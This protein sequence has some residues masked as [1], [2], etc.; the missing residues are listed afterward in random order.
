[1]PRIARP[2][3]TSLRHDLRQDALLQQVSRLDG[4]DVQAG[5][6]MPGNVAVERP[7]AWVVGVVLQDEITVLAGGRAAGLD[8]LH[9]AALGVV[10]MGDLSVPFADPFRQDVEI[11]AVQMHRVRDGEFVLYDEADRVV[12]PKVV[13]VP[14]G[15]EWVGKVALVREDEDWVAVDNESANGGLTRKRRNAYS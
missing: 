4:V 7:D 15:V 14:L 12:V 13:D 10:L 11:V 3:D 9:I 1:M 6:D 5:A 8:E 2:V